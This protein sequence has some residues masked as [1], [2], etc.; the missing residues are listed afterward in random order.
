[1]KE[2]WQNITH[3]FVAPSVTFAR[4]KTQPKWGMA[5]ILFCLLQVGVTWA[6]APFTDRLIS[7]GLAREQMPR[8]LIEETVPIIGSFVLAFAL[9]VPLIA[10]VVL[11]VVLTFAARIFR[12]DA[13]VRFRHI[14]ASLV[15]AALIP[16]LTYFVNTALVPVLRGLENVWTPID[17]QVVPGLHLLSASENMLLLMFLS[18]FNPLSI[19]PV[20][21]LTIAVSILADI[22][23]VKASVVAILIWLSGVALEVLAFR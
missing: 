13:A 12:V 18:H 21:V 6:V 5:L 14:Y 19:W 11:S 22:G 4:L 15:H 8:Y 20:V 2:S 16:T 1:M 23:K 7:L 9:I 17:M 10:T 3:L